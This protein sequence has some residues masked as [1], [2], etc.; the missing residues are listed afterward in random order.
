MGDC[1]STSNDAAC[2]LPQSRPGFCPACGQKGKSVTTLTVKSLVR[3]HTRVPADGKYSFCRTPDCETVYFSDQVTFRKPELKVRVGL[4]EHE[5]PVPVCY[6]FEYTRADVRR[7]LVEMG[8]TDIPDRVKSEV[9]A[10]FCACEVKNPSG[11]CCLGD[12]IRAVQEVRSSSAT[13][14]RAGEHRAAPSRKV[15]E[16]VSKNA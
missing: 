16:A 1:C 4:K 10:G 7:D 2:S 3:D 14:V 12:V 6:C 5:D 8:K 15:K 11:S 9:Q 13:S